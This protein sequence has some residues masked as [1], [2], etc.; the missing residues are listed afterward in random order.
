M[1][2]PSPVP[3]IFLFLVS[4]SLA[5]DSNSFSISSLRIPIPVSRTETF[6]RYFSS[7][8]TSPEIVRVTFP[9]SVYFTALVRRFMITCRIRT[10]SP[11]SSHGIVLSTLSTNSRPF[12]FARSKIELKRSLI[13]NETSYFTGTSSIFPSSIF[14]KSRILLISDR[15]VLPADLIL[16]A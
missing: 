16:A 10:S 7:S 5:K 11:K 15:S 1:D 8:L 9:F 13:I 3:S 4:S 12:F 2:M 6:N 14:E